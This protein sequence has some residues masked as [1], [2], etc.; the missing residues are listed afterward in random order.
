MFLEIS[1]GYYVKT[2]QRRGGVGSKG[3]IFVKTLKYTRG[4]ASGQ[5]L[6]A[7]DSKAE[8]ALPKMRSCHKEVWS[9]GGEGRRVPVT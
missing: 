1:G 6:T 8:Q 4:A 7:Q 9:N 3:A 5:G 2:R